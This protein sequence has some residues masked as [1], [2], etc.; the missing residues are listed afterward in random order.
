MSS[1]LGDIDHADHGED[2]VGVYVA[3][4]IALLVLLGLTLAA[5]YI[6]FSQ[7]EIG[8]MKLDFLN[9]VI[10]LTIASIKALLVMLFFMHLRHSTKLTW[11]I[12]AAGFV[13]LAIMVSFTFADYLSRKAIPEN[14]AQPPPAVIQQQNP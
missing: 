2:S 10:A 1:K 5:Y 14:W 8:G 4:F 12:A 9:T 13:W 3:V 6:D 11:V 7:R